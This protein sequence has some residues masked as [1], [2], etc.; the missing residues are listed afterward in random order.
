MYEST[1]IVAQIELGEADLCKTWFLFD[2]V[3]QQGKVRAL[4]VVG[5]LDFWRGSLNH[6]WACQ[7][8]RPEHEHQRHRMLPIR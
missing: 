1:L 8:P 3:R 6:H 2:I 4:W 7:L 5:F